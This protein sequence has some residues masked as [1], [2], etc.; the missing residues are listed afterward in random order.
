MKEKTYNKKD[1]SQGV[2]Y[3]LEAEDIFI[4]KE[5]KQYTTKFGEMHKVVTPEG[6][7][8]TLTGGQYSFFE[9]NVVNPGTAVACEEYTNSYGT[10]IG[11]R[12]SNAG[13][14][15]TT[16]VNTN[17]TAQAGLPSLNKTTPATIPLTVDEETCMNQLLGSTELAPWKEHAKKNVANF[18]EALTGVAEKIGV[19]LVLGAERQKIMYDI[20]LTKL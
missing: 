10:F 2:D 19:K 9:R 1:G 12:F 14:N 7:Y 15:T 8:I 16:A 13:D 20:F 3:K 4:F 5:I 11:L 6:K 17:T 18:M